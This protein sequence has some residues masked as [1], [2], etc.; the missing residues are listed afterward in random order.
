MI[1]K[2]L[3]PF[4]AAVTI[5]WAWFGIVHQHQIFHISKPQIENSQKFCWLLLQLRKP[6]FIPRIIS[7]AR[8]FM[9]NFSAKQIA[10]YL[11][12]ISSMNI[13]HW[14][15]PNAFLKQYWFCYCCCSWCWKQQLENPE[16]ETKSIPLWTWFTKVWRK[17]Y[18]IGMFWL[19]TAF[20][21]VFSSAHNLRQCRLQA[22]S[23]LFLIFFANRK[24]RRLLNWIKCEWKYNSIGNSE[25][26]CCV[27]SG[28]QKTNIELAE[29]IK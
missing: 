5:Q 6:S 11:I 9:A 25:L 21:C 23:L 14:R 24:C 2:E 13:P 18:W 3:N 17:T 1:L 10:S 20:D 12:R 27:P 19:S 29:L 8:K 26:N 16:E 28:R 15:M 22:A 7:C 4:L